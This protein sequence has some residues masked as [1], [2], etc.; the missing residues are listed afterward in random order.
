MLNEVSASARRAFPRIRAKVPIEIIR[1]D[2]PCGEPL[3]ATLLDIS[4]SGALLLTAT[5][6]PNG[7]WI[8]IQ[9]DRRGA[10]FGTELTAIVDR[11]LT[12]EQPQANLTCRFP[13]PVDYSVLRLFV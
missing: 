13:Q 4:Q 9:P 2:N 1:A 10:G 3:A 12:P 5:A 6:I 11:N 8:V 7:E